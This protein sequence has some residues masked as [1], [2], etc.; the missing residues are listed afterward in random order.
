MNNNKTP[1]PFAPMPPWAP[2]RALPHA[3]VFYG[4]PWCSPAFVAKRLAGT[5]AT[6]R[7][8]AAPWWRDAGAGTVSAMRAQA[9]W[10]K[11]GGSA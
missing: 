11:A 8:H 10:L 4:A 3:A 6:W 1:N 2:P 9:A 7:S 5:V